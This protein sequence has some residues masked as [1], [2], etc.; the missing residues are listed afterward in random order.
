MEKVLKVQLLLTT[1]LV[2]LAVFPL[3]HAVLP[4][5][6]EIIRTSAV[7][8]PALWAAIS[9]QHAELCVVE[10]VIILPGTPTRAAICVLAGLL[11][12]VPPSGAP[13]GAIHTRSPP[14]R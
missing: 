5:E 2:A 9:P 4:A 14:F 10:T 11:A 8:D 6:F 7:S 13:S 3:A 1:V 12:G